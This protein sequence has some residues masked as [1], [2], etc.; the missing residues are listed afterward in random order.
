M[1]QLRGPLRGMVAVHSGQQVWW[2]W[3]LADFQ[4]S[5]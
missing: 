5:D 1:S 3:Q 2:S 4:T